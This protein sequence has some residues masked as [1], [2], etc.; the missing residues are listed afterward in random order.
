MKKLF[1]I[2]VILLCS[3]LALAGG[4]TDAKKSVIARQS[5]AGGASCTTSNDSD[6]VAYYTGDCATDDGNEQISATQW[7]AAEFT[8]SD[9][10]TITEY[11]ARV[12]CWTDA[13]TLVLQIYDDNSGEPDETSPVSGTDVAIN[14]GDLEYRTYGDETFT[15]ATPQE[16]SAGTYWVV[17]K[18][19]S[20]G[21]FYWANDGAGCN[22]GNAETTDSGSTW[23]SPANYG[24]RM[25][26][27]GCE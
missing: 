19:T 24:F 25:I 1:I 4:V 12:N 23:T 7:K 18:G 5:V 10:T 2:I 27:R 13:G 15:L 11:Q 14:S 20:T 6:I 8:L 17:A 9:T 3:S 26:M 22:Y 21:V 16:L